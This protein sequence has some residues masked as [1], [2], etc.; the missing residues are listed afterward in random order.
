[1]AAQLCPTRHRA[2]PMRE[3]EYDRLRAAAAER[4][5]HEL[6]H[7]RGRVAH[8]AML[9]IWEAHQRFE[10]PVAFSAFVEEAVRQEADF[11]RRKHAALRHRDGQA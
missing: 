8:K 4:L 10:S 11:Q 7:F 2:L 3:E 6:A 5:G 9:D 1:M